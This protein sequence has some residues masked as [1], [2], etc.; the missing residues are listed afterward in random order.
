MKIIFVC[1]LV[2][3]LIVGVQAGNVAKISAVADGYNGKVIDFEFIDNPA[4]N[5]QFPYVDKKLMEFEVELKEPTLMKVNVWMWMIVCPG[6]EIRVDIH[7]NGKNYRTAEFKGTPSAVALNE[8]I[9]DGRL[10]RVEGR[11]KTNPLAAVVTGVPVKEYYTAT[12]QNWETE[13]A[14]LE[15]VRSK[16]DPFAFNYIYAELEGMYM[17]NLVRYPLIVSDVNKKELAGCI[18]DGYW[19]V[20]D[21]YR[22]KDDKA[23]LKSY[24]YMAWLLNYME[25][26]ERCEAVRVGK[27]YHYDAD[28]QKNYDSLAGFY[29]GAVRD[30]V[31]YV[32]LYNAISSQKDFDLI[33]KLSKDYFKKYNKNKKYRAELTE[34]QK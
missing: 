28:L 8:A 33:A 19:N 29:D 22:V 17:S 2:C 7:F 18:P 1:V 12:L 15:K 21:G 11:Y 24:T 10:N 6:D 23:S 3:L 16:V 27:E 31:L 34:M 25:Y 26:A 32:F 9:R 5:M 30:A 20:L 4:N 13:K 14:L